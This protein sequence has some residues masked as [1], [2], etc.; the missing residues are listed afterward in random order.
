M[1]AKAKAQPKGNVKAAAKKAHAGKAKPK[2]LVLTAAQWKAYNKAYTAA[3]KAARTRIAFRAASARF[4]KGRLGAAT[5]TIRAYNAAHSSARAAAVASYAAHLSLIQS[6]QSHQNAALSHRV[7]QDAVRHATMYGRLAYAAAGEHA[8]ARRAI[9]RTVDE[10]QANAHERAAFARIARIAKK[11]S[12]SLK[13]PRHKPASAVGK[14][15]SAAIRSAGK[16]AGLKAARA[17]GGG[18]PGGRGKSARQGTSKAGRPAKAAGAA[19]ARTAKSAAK[20]SAASQSASAKSAKAPVKGAKPRTAPPPFGGMPRKILP[21]TSG[22]L[23]WLGDEDTP[24]CVVIAVANSLLRTWGTI[25]ITNRDL[26]ELA[27]DCGAAPAIEEALWQAWLT[28]WPRSCRA[29]LAGYAPALTGEENGEVLVGGLIVGYE[30]EN[31]PHAA[32]SLPGKRVVSWGAVTDLTAR[33]EEAW[34][35]R[36]EN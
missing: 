2:G 32:L 35:V 21:G 1:A 23:K 36:W 34:E 28:G 30:T 19:S 4:R 8:F 17:I 31:G 20:A 16:A 13:N 25:T 10:A 24:N 29:H 5:S 27:Q 33:V 11:G 3:A 7:Q 26:E 18:S 15:Q 12:K 6:Q 22:Q 14:A 9:A